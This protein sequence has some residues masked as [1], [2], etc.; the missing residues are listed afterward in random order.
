[1]VQ[2]ARWKGA[3]VTATASAAN[4]D[5]VRALGADT[6]IDYQKTRFE[7]AVKDV[8]AVIDTVGGDLIERSLQVVR[9]G[10]IFVTVAGRVDPEMGQARGVQ[11]T[12]SR[13]ADSARLKEISELL[14][15]QT[16]KPK[17]RKVF[18]LAEARQAH[19]LSETGHGQG[20][21]VLQMS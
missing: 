4:V 21:I 8:D 19:E 10:G 7:D 3:R 16:L 2:L 11:V 14:E 17:V 5:F 1:A 18:P 15:T 6:V 20:R 12:S 9:P 13:H